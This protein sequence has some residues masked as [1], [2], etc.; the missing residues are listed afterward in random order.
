MKADNLSF[1]LLE[2]IGDNEL[3]IIKGCY[4]KPEIERFVSIDKEEFYI[5]GIQDE[6][7]FRRHSYLHKQY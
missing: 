7:Y 3:E 2:N 5:C 6:A 1:V 4:C